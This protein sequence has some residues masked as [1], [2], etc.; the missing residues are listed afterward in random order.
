[1]TGDAGTDWAAAAFNDLTAGVGSFGSDD[2]VL[3]TPGQGTIVAVAPGPGDWAA[4]G[5]SL[6]D[7]NSAD[8]S[9]GTAR[10]LIDADKECDLGLE[11]VPPRWRS[12]SSRGGP[13]RWSSR[14]RTPGTRACG[15]AVSVPA[16]YAA[17]PARRRRP[18][19]DRGAGRR[20]V[21]HALRR[22][23]HLRGARRRDDITTFSVAAAGDENAANN[24]RRCASTSSTATC[25]CRSEGGGAG[26]FPTRRP[27][28][29]R[30]E[31]SATS[32]RRP[33]AGSRSGSP[34]AAARREGRQLHA[35][36]R[37]QRV[38]HHRRRRPEGRQ[39]R[40]QATGHR[41]AR[42]RRATSTPATTPPAYGRSSSA[43]ATRG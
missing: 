7:L 15:G 31:R 26:A 40:R 3:A 2:T 5:G 23:A 20:R 25:G 12:P 10:L 28:A 4:V 41:C 39:A 30:S 14:S 38:R 35:R 6:L 29:S 9:F 24:V 42:P 18:A 21:D 43:S 32:G 37:P 13:S 22:A 17:C 27:R 34:A 1:M 16:P 11:V 19:R 8:T 33:A 36:V